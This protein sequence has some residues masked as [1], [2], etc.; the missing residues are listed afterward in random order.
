MTPPAGSRRW[1]WRALVSALAGGGIT[2]AGL[3]PISGGALAAEGT[4]GRRARSRPTTPART[5]TTTDDQRPTTT[6]TTRRRRARQRRRARRRPPRHRRPRRP[7]TRPPARRKSRRRPS[8]PR[9]DPPWC[10]SAGRKRRPP[11]TPAARRTTTGARPAGRRRQQQRRGRAAGRRRAGR[12]AGGRTGRLGGIDAGARL[13]PHPAVPAAD[14]PG[15]GGPVRRALA[16]PRGDQRNRDQLRH[17]SVGVDGRA[18]WAGCS[19]CPRP[20]SSTASTR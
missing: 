15:R 19:S 14:L 10:S 1:V 6:T 8:P 13:L 17:R 18:R 7:R 16:D 11:R 4:T 12:S 3:G 5:P 2:A 9:K 20:G